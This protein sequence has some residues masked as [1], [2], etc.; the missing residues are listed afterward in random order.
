MHGEY[1]RELK[2]EFVPEE[3]DLVTQDGRT[4]HTLL[5]AK[6]ETDTEGRVIGM[7]A[8]FLDITAR[9]KAE[10]ETK[11]LEAALMQAQKMEAIGTLA[12]GIAHD[13]NNILSAVIGYTELAL[14]NAEKET[15]LYENIQQVHLAGMRAGNLVSQILA[16]SRQSEQELKP[17]QVGPLIKEALKLLRSSLPTTVEIEQKIST[18]LDNVMGDPTQIQQIVMNL[19]TNAAH[20]MEEEGGQMT[21]S[22]SQVTLTRKDYHRYPDLSPGRYIKLSVQDTGK[23]ISP[24]IMEKIYHPYFTTKEK[25]KGTGLGLSVVHGI[26]RSYGGAVDVVSEPGKGS[27]FNVYIPTIRKH[28]LPVEQPDVVLPVGSERILLVDDEPALTDVSLK[29][30]EMMGY[31]V[32]AVN[33][34]L[35]ALEIFHN[36][37]QDFDLVISDMTM[38]K[39]AGNKLAANLLEIRPDLPVIL[40]TGYSDNISEEKAVEIGVKALVFKPLTKKDLAKIVREVLDKAKP[41][42]GGI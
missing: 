40:C 12:G 23:G 20:A 36:T 16:F 39:M 24:E 1:H 11:R 35:E 10:H 9:K 19:C 22:L 3:C 2:V 26:V 31:H 33:D 21:V 17:L 7:R 30:L 42:T 38:P 27:S 4:V 41:E 8:M 29:M 13:F 34:S 6:P 14:E 15:S 32:T 18:K 25:G 28:N 5:H 37:P